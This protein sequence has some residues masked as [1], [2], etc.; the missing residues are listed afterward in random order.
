MIKIRRLVDEATDLAVRATSGVAFLGQQNTSGVP[1]QMQALGLAFGHQPQPQTRLSSERKHRM[2]EQAVQKLAEAYRI[3]EIT[4]SV[5]TMQGTSSL[6][7]VAS[8]VLQRNPD[9]VDAKYVHFFHEKIPSRQVA[10]NTNLTILDEIIHGCMTNPGPLRTRGVVRT[11]NE[12]YQGAAKDLTE[13][14]RVHLLHQPVHK[15]PILN[16][17]KPPLETTASRKQGVV[18]PK[19]EDQPT[20]LEMQLHFQ[21]AGAY[22]NVAANHISA[23]L[24]ANVPIGEAESG[25]EQSSPTDEEAQKKMAEARKLV[26][27]NAKKALRDYTTFLSHF[28]YS[29]NIPIEIADDFTRKVVSAGS[30]ILRP[31][32]HKGLRSP[33]GETNEAAYKPHRVYALPDLFTSSP[34]AGLPSCPS[35]KDASEAAPAGPSLASTGQLR[36]TTET[37]TYHPLVTEALHSIL[38]CHCLIQTSAKELLRHANMVARL[39]RLADGY[40]LFQSSWC[41]AKIEWIRVLRTTKNWLQLSD[42][43]E[44]LCALAPL[45]LFHSTGDDTA[46]V[47]ISATNAQ[48]KLEVT[49]DQPSGSS[50]AQPDQP[51]ALQAD[52][53]QPSSHDDRL[54]D[55]PAVRMAIRERQMR[56][57]RGYHVDRTVAS[58]DPELTG[59]D[60]EEPLAGAHGPGTT[61]SPTALAQA[62]SPAQDPST[63]P[64]ENRPKHQQQQTITPIP[65]LDQPPSYLI[66]RAN[67]IARWVNQAPT[68]AGGGEG[69]TRRRKKKKGS[70]T[71]ALRKPGGSLGSQGCERVSQGVGEQEGEEE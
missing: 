38:L 13:A 54:A 26:R 36:I 32:S 43:W 21:R 35:M 68:G 11:F 10:G 62:S 40:P 29:P 14:L 15:S 45:Q 5:A 7:E 71:V 42:S 27:H 69:G 20:A 4:T 50:P 33:G 48:Q 28:E 52:T 41:P 65:G 47:P 1:S 61:T 39:A 37:L 22:L 3:D 66:D 70:A 17:D 16:Q 19:A 60:L 55:E 67:R 59:Y 2:R 57:Q 9:N 25:P 46:P 24:P 6:E 53:K 51:P 56:A 64:P 8:V 63:T 49:T 12:D 30:R 23:A 31:H 58:M 44:N 34:P 18:T